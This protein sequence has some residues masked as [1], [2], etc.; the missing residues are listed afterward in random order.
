DVDGD[1]D[2]DAVVANA[3]ISHTVHLNDGA[4]NFGAASASFGG[5]P[6]WDIALGDVDGDGDLDAVIA[7]GTTQAVH[8]NNGSGNFGPATAVSGIDSRG[9][10]LGDVDGDGDLDMVVATYGA[11]QQLHRNDGQGNFGP[12]T[13]FGSGNSTGLALADV[14]GDLDPDVVVANAGGE[15]QAVYL[16][17][18]SGSFGPAAT[19]GSGDSQDVVLGDVD[20]DGD[21]DAIVVNNGAAQTVHFNNGSGVFSNIALSSLAGSGGKAARLGDLDGDGDLDV[22]SAGAGAETVHLNEDLTDLQLTKTG[23]PFLATPGQA[24]TYTLNFTNAGPGVAENVTIVDD[25]PVTLTNISVASAGVALQQTNNGQRYTWSVLRLAANSGG[26]IT[27]TGILSSNLTPQPLFNTATITAT[28]GD[29][30]AGTNQATAGLMISN[31]APVL[32]FIPNQT[33]TETQTLTFTIPATDANGD[34]LTYGLNAAPGGAAVDSLGRF[35]WTPTEAQGGLS[36]TFTVVVSDTGTPVLTDSQQ[37]VVTVLKANTAPVLA[38][39]PNQ[40][41]TETQTL[42]FTAV[43]TDSD[44]PAQTLTYGLYNAPTGAT[45][46]SSGHF[47]WTPTEAQGGNGFSGLAYIFSVVVTDSLG[48][49]DFQVVTVNATEINQAPVLA[50]IGDQRIVELQPFTLTLSA[51]DADLPA[52]TLTYSLVNTPTGAALVGNLF[53][54]TPTANQ[55][56]GV[57]P[58]TFTVSD[59]GAPNLTDSEPITITVNNPPGVIVTESGGSTQV[60]EGGVTDTYT[61]VLNSSPTATVTISM[62]TDSQVTT[63]P[64]SVSFSPANWYMTRTITV[65]AVDDTLYE[66]PRTSLISHTVSSSD[67]AYNGIGSAGVTATISDDSEDRPQLSLS[68][69]TVAEGVGTAAVSVTLTG[70]SVFS[71]GVSYSISNGT[72]LGG[73]VDYSATNGT[74]TWAAYTSG[75]QSIN[76]TIIDDTLHE[77]T[78]TVNLAL[79]SPISATLVKDSGVLTITDNDAPAAL[80]ISKTVVISGPIAIPGDPVTYTIILS[81][82]GST[83]ENVMV[84]DTLP[85]GLS[86]LSLSQTTTIT[87]FESITYTISATV[88]N[89]PA[90]YTATITNTAAFTYGL[91]TGQAVAAFTTISDTTPPTFT[92]SPALIT[93]TNS[94][95]ISN[96]RPTFSWTAADDGLSGV[97]YYTLQ[98][99]TNHNNLNIQAISKT[100]TTTQTSYTPTNALPGGVYTWTVR[101]HDRVGNTSDYVSP[102][103]SFSISNGDIYLPLIMKAGDGPL[104]DLT[105]TNIQ[106]TVNG[107]VIV[108]L[109]NNGPAAVT[110]AF[111]VDVYYNQTPALNTP[112][113]VWWGLSE[114]NGGVPIAAGAEVTLSLSSPYLAGG[115]APASSSITVQGLVDSFGPHSY[116]NVRES[117]E[118]NNIFGAVNPT[119]ASAENTSDLGGTNPNFDGRGL[120]GR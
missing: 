82:S 47:T 98:V 117:N 110:D 2:L 87:A 24:I 35:T 77:I 84:Q 38:F 68:D 60:S 50:A 58:M 18:G 106:A 96:T 94:V 79:T 69:L 56:P 52:N 37:V 46:D 13:T 120:P 72:A 115:S 86:G 67:P 8:L 113:Q 41:I 43:A 1:G 109:R 11:A 44:L 73:G 99:E 76:I 59:N 111:W 93:P 71:T 57:Y 104:P 17:N 33:I 66:G 28:S 108:T 64:E 51:T 7:N 101:A 80:T 118:G 40:T 85:A 114:A 95:V 91:T 97:D 55:G 112:G 90:N 14:D 48:L 12:A 116:G 6:G 32:P 45:I 36:Y 42:T 26:V 119:E 31:A 5:G 4:G 70:Q 88:L 27:I 39:I 9:V 20:G 100:I 53:S 102:A 63:M 75:T 23:Q 78:E 29:S 21:P 22:V 62:T 16:N 54:W 65:T 107:D 89:I 74:L 92:V 81:N 25:L 105:I 3:S 30:I 34:T 83:A 49:T 19:F 103:A 15:A 10:A 61:I